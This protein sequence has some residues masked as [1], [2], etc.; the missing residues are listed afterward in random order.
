M[1]EEERSLTCLQKHLQKAAV[2]PVCAARRRV[3]VRV[4]VR[5]VHLCRKSARSKTAAGEDADLPVRW[6]TQQSTVVPGPALQPS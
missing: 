1:W 2:R 3:R 5:G 6:R 4:R